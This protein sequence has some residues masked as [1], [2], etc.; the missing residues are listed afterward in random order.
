MTPQQRNRICVPSHEVIKRLRLT[1][2]HAEPPKKKL[3]NTMKLEKLASYCDPSRK[4]NLKGEKEAGNWKGR[5]LSDGCAGTLVAVWPMCGGRAGTLQI[6]S[7]MKGHTQLRRSNAD[8]REKWQVPDINV[9]PF[10]KARRPCSER[11]SRGSCS[12]CSPRP[13]SQP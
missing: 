3:S 5:S 4:R 8:S 10:A 2:S 13:C 7:V 1:N 6:L 12:T 9:A 11:A